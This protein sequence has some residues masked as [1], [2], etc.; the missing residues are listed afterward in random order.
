MRIRSIRTSDKKRLKRFHAGLSE[1]SVYQRFFEFKERLNDRD[2]R[3]L[4]EVDSV[5]HV[6]LVATARK[7]LRQ[8]IA[9]VAR[10][11][12]TET[13]DHPKKADVALTVLDE[14]QGKG[15]GT[16]LFRHLASIATAQGVDEFQAEVLGENR[17]MMRVF[18]HSG[19]PLESRIASGI[20]TVRLR[21]DLPLAATESS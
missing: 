3:Y 1:R 15:L 5:R 16:A 7:W 20:A 13:Q 8:E 11:A 17:E 12:S 2:L 21:L 4:T 9:G 10:Y 19:Y 6:A 14:Y 18:E